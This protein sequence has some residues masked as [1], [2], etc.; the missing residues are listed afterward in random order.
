MITPEQFTN[1]Q[2][3]EWAVNVQAVLLGE[4]KKRG[5]K[6]PSETLRNLTVMVTGQTF[7]LAFQD[8]GRHVDM[9]SLDYSKR[10]I[11]QGDN[12]ILRWVSRIGV[13]RFRYIPGYERGDSSRL[14]TEQ[15]E[16]RVAS[17]IIASRGSRV[18]LAKRRRGA[19]WFN[20]TF[21]SQVEQLVRQLLNNY[22]EYVLER[23]KE[24]IQTT[25]TGK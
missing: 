23:T 12:F 18:K 22:P 24:D 2:L 8:S 3:R 21:Y 7:Q 11:A 14:T 1:I 19:R 15:K 13:E 4:L 16:E 6:V 20:Q 17:A 10:A 25:L 5:K 9:R